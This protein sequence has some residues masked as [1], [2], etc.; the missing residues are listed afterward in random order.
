M[1]LKVQTKSLSPAKVQKCMRTTHTHCEQGPCVKNQVWA[2]DWVTHWCHSQA[3]ESAT[4]CTGTSRAV[5]ARLSSKQT[6][7]IARG[8]QTC[9]FLCFMVSYQ[10]V[11][12]S[13]KLSVGEVRCNVTNETFIEVNWFLIQVFWQIVKLF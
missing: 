1:Q 11:L 2:K 4:R 8:K 7:K 10:L 9:A 5:Q 12:Q 3:S 6:H 13:L